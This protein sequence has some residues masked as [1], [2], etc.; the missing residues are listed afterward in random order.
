[1]ASSNENTELKLV[2]SIRYKFAAVSGDEKRLGAAL[3]SQLTSLL[4]K[5]GSQHKAV[6]DDTFKAFMS[7]KT[8]VKPSGVIL[9]VAALLE[10]Y[11]RTTSPIVK[12]LDL[13]FIRE[14]LPRLDQSKR[15]DLLPLA[16]RDISKEMNS[17]SAAGFFNVFLRLLL[18]IKFPG[19][20]SAEDLVLQESVGLANPSDAKYVADWLG[21]LFLLRQDI[22]LAPEDE[23]PA[24]LEAS[25]SGLTKEDVAFLRNKDPKSW[26]PNTPNS[27]SLPECKT[28]AVGFLASGAFKDDERYLPAIYAAGSADSRISSVADD[29]LKRASIDFESES[30]VQS[31]FAAHSVLPGAQRIQI[32]RLLSKSIAA[33]SSKQQIV[34]AVTEDFALTTGEKPTISGLEALRLHQALLGFLSWIARNNFEVGLTDTKMGPA[35][36]MILKDYILRQGWPAANARSNQSQSQDEQRLRAN[37]YGTIGILARYPIPVRT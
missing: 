17:A 4:E 36:V 23:I 37:A 8:F 34:D 1:M 10:Q 18:E 15:R 12:Q 21:K 31:L 22:A 25:P 16:L 7:V 19:R 27:L 6:R 30:L 11:K 33:C 28:K 20:G 26:K 14:G 5:A 13:A 32:L 3:Q 24:K 9:P 2:S 29:I 35:L